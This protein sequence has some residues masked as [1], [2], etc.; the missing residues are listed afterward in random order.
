MNLRKIYTVLLTTD[1]AV[2][3]AARSYSGADAQVSGCRQWFPRD[4]RSFA[5]TDPM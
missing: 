3:A 2:A 4:R 5:A 1:L